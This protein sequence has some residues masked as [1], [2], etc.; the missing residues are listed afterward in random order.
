M[1]NDDKIWLRGSREHLTWRGDVEVEHFDLEVSIDEQIKQQFVE[2]LVDADLNDT[3]EVKHMLNGSLDF[4]HLQTVFMK[5]SGWNS[6][7]DELYLDFGNG[8]HISLYYNRNNS[9]YS[10]S[11]WCKKHA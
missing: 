6:I 11:A 5:K 9:L 2:K 1:K 7:V 8:W 4:K 10:Y 3:T